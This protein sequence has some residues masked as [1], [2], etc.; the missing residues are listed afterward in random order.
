MRGLL[1]APAALFLAFPL[2]AAPIDMGLSGPAAAPGG[3]SQVP[4]TGN[5]AELDQALARAE[6]AAAELEALLRSSQETV[7]GAASAD[8]GFRENYLAKAKSD[9]LAAF[10]P[11]DIAAIAPDTERNGLLERYLACTALAAGDGGRCSALPNYSVRG[12]RDD[13]SAAE[14]CL[15]AYYLLRFLDARWSGADAG[16]VCRQAHAARGGKDDAASRCAAAASGRCEGLEKLAW[17]PFEDRAH[18][19]GA[20]APD[21][22][23]IASYDGDDLGY[24]CADLA[25]LRA[26]RKGGSCGR[27][28]LCAALVNRDPKA[29]D[30]LYASTRESY[31][32][33]LVK[34]KELREQALLQAA[35]TDRRSKPSPRR[36]AMDAV[37]EKRKAVDSFLVQLGTQLDGFE[38][39]TVDGFPERVQRYRAVR[40]RVDGALK[41]FKTASEG[42]AKAAR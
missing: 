23:K 4:A 19:T 2:L 9:C 41:R 15:D 36:S 16:A 37:A 38:P 6:A 42:P 24:A 30:A 29:C 11:T 14:N 17:T 7:K 21:C 1:A 31:C 35:E 25:A 26:A 40:R 13:R 10:R 33:G 27:S 5:L 39:K 20:L 28:A 12:P 3:Q 18:C 8:A 34:E 22:A 32:T